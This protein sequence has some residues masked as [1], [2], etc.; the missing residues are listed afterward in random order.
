M[1][2][3]PP[4]VIAT[5]N[6]VAHA[7]TTAITLLMGRSQ[8]RGYG[9]EKVQVLL[10]PNL[11]TWAETAPIQADPRCK[12]T[13]QFLPLFAG[14]REN[15]RRLAEV[16][17]SI[18]TFTL[19]DRGVG[20]Y[21][22]DP[23]THAIM[24]RERAF[25]INPLGMDPVRISDQKAH[26]RLGPM[27][28]EGYIYYY[29]HFLKL[30]PD[31]L[32][33]EL[34]KRLQQ[35]RDRIQIFQLK[36]GAKLVAGT[37]GFAI[38]TS[39]QRSE[40]G[41][42]IVASGINTLDIIAKLPKGPVSQEFLIRRQIRLHEGL[43][44]EQFVY[45]IAEVVDDRHKFQIVNDCPDGFP[46]QIEETVRATP[47][48]STVIVDRASSLAIIPAHA[49]ETDPSEAYRLRAKL[50]V[51]GVSVPGV[52]AMAD[53]PVICAYLTDMARQIAYR[54][55][56]IR[57]ITD[58]NWLARWRISLSE[59]P[60]LGNVDGTEPVTSVQI[61]NNTCIGCPYNGK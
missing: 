61:L 14:N 37:S 46:R 15:T 16:L 58:K 31:R 59:I 25:L 1:V 40:L 34:G 39:S 7:V 26:D 3:Q 2:N 23:H 18:E 5:H 60:T 49:P 48:P 13:A 12:R 32:A 57:Q 19:L 51:D 30:L 53:T 9:V 33:A 24:E 45:T 35:A 47:P 28:R 38:E 27:Y 29:G 54:D 20:V 11:P 4:I 41:A 55:Y 8:L 22:I 52:F 43:P 17:S 42:T 44:I 6:D 56:I 21:A 36:P 50:V 10:T